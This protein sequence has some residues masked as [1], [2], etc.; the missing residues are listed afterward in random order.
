MDKCYEIKAVNKEEGEIY[1]YKEIYSWAGSDS[2]Y[3]VS[4]KNF[5]RELRELGDIKTLNIY[6]NSPGGDVFEGQAM[7]NILKRKSKTCNVIVHIDG[8]S[9]SIASVI[10]MAGDKVIMPANAMMMIHRSSCYVYGNTNELIKQAEVLKKVDK[11]IK[12]AYL[13]HCNGKLDE[14]TLESWLDSGDT[15]LTA[16]ECF[17]YG[18]CDEITDSIEIAAKYD[19]K[20]LSN[21]NNVPDRFKNIF[22][23]N[24]EKIDEE[25]QI[26]IN[27]VNT[28][29]K[30]W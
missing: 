25:A 30:M 17:Q 29:S 10:T 22:K 7:Y 26:L 1:I 6:I 5:E 27:K 14:E 24:K 23:K 9:A 21:L 8:L 13:E 4:A 18:L 3:G 2:E 11:A 19:E 12:S 15:W 20:S 16:D 28:M